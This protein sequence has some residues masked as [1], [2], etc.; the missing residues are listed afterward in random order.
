MPQIQ[1]CRG[2]LGSSGG[3]SPKG[4]DGW[5]RFVTCD[6][7]WGVLSK[8]SI[9]RS[10]G[11][12][13]NDGWG[14][15]GTCDLCWGVLSNDRSMCSGRETFLLSSRGLA[16]CWYLVWLRCGKSWCWESPSLCRYLPLCRYL[17]F[18]NDLAA[19]ALPLFVGPPVSCSRLLFS[20]NRKHHRGQLPAAGLGSLW[21]RRRVSTKYLC[22]WCKRT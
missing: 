2:S 9:K 13:S 19:K 16:D 4:R 21:K 10:W 17:S 8:G 6:L 3:C 11:V 18:P 14:R 7:C 5:G 1:Q 12:L 22:F 20:V 15:L